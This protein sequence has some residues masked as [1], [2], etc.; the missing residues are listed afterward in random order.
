MQDR[1]TASPLDA[2]T[3]GGELTE[4]EETGDGPGSEMVERSGMT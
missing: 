2:W 3:S 4:M 1:E